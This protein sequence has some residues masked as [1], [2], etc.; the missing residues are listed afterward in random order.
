MFYKK[1]KVMKRLVQATNTCNNMTVVEGIKRCCRYVPG[2]NIPSD[3][4]CSSNTFQKRFC[5]NRVSIAT[6]AAVINIILYIL[7]A[8]WDK[9]EY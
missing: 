9:G 8:A 2:Y 6:K 5:R 7:A 3:G 1:I 4:R